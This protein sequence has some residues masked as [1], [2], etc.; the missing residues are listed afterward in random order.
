MRNIYTLSVCSVLSGLRPGLSA[1]CSWLRPGDQETWPANI[2]HHAA[3]G[4]AASG[5]AAVTFQHKMQRRD[6]RERVEGTIRLWEKMWQWVL[7]ILWQ[8]QNISVFFECFTFTKGPDTFKGSSIKRKRHIKWFFVFN[9]SLFDLLKYSIVVVAYITNVYCSREC[10][11]NQ[12]VAQSRN[13]G[14][15]LLKASWRSL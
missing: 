1:G 6:R 4:H 14:H 8:S 3:P 2:S 11:A 10:W 12:K 7:L 15:D 5:K 9:N 13:L